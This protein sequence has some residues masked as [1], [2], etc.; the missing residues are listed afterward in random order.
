[1][2]VQR[3]IVGDYVASLGRAGVAKDAGNVG[4][5][6]KRRGVTCVPGAKVVEGIKHLPAAVRIRQ[7]P[8]ESL[9]LSRH[10]EGPDRRCFVCVDR[11]PPMIAGRRGRGVKRPVENVPL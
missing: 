5:P 9:A 11:H 10:D 6:R 1:L 8:E 3:G 7:Q 4:R 2:A